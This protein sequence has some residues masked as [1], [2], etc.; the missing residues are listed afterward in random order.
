MRPKTQQP[1]GPFEATLIWITGCDKPVL[2][3]RGLIRMVILGVVGLALIRFSGVGDGPGVLLLT[4]LSAGLVLGTV[5][6]GIRR[7]RW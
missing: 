5:I 7:G 2:N 3:G 6:E 1:A 4:G